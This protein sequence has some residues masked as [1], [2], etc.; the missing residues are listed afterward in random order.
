LLCQIDSLDE[1]IARFDLETEAYCRPYEEAVD[2]LDPILGVGREVAGIIVSKIGA[3]LSHFPSVD[4][5]AA[6]AGV[7]LGNYESA[8]KRRSGKPRQSMLSK[9]RLSG[10]WRDRAIYRG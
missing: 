8:G 6:W 5:L 9:T 1:T 7:A 10:N 3:D 4:H 2:L